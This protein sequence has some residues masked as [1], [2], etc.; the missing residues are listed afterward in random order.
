MSELVERFVDR[1]FSIS[2][3]MMEGDNLAILLCSNF[4]NVDQDTDGDT[5]WTPDAITGYNEVKQALHEHFRPVGDHIEALEA[6][7]RDLRVDIEIKRKR[8]EDADTELARVTELAE[9][10]ARA[11]D[12]TMIGGNHLA[13]LIGP[14]H[15]PHTTNPMD[16]LAHYGACDT[17]E[18]W[19]YWRAV[20][21]ARNALA[22]W[23]ARDD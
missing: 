16:A 4:E 7:N 13:L 12:S 9:G 11:L 23:E 17:Y 10:M 22:A 6:A 20:M 18:I 1:A 21:I 5:G 8:L 2:T 15:P 19:C 14:E 3:P